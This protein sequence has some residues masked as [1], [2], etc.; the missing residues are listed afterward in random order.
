MQAEQL[1]RE[2][3]GFETFQPG[4]REVIDR[5]LDGR[6]AAAVFPTGGGKSLCYQ[7]PALALP[8][9]TVVVSPLIALMIDQVDRLQRRGIAAERLDSTRSAAE[10]ANIASDVRQ[11]RLKLL[12][13]APERLQ[14]ERLRG[15]LEH[16]QVSLLAIDEA[17]CISEWGHA[18]RPD[19][20]KLAPYAKAIGAERV[21]ALTATATA[22]VLSDICREFSIAPDCA[23]RTPF[24]RPN[25]HLHVTPTS[26]AQREAQLI[27]RLRQRPA[28]PT[29]VYVTLQRTAEQAAASLKKAGFDARPYHA[30]LPDDVRADTQAWFMQSA[31]G[32][33]AATIAFGMGIDKSDI[34]YVYHYNLAKSLESYSQEIGRAG[35]DGLP[36]TCEMFV[37]PDDL[38][39]LENFAYGDTPSPANVRTALREILSLG[40]EFSVSM[41]DLSMRHDIRPLVLSTLLT[42]LELDGV[43]QAG[44]P[45]YAEY[46]FQPLISSREI[47]SHFDGER[48]DFLAAVLREAVKAKTWFTLDLDLAATKIAST[49]DR[50]AKAIDYL[51]EQRWLELKVAGLRARYRRLKS[52]SD[53]ESLASSLQERLA[54]REHRE[55]ARLAGVLEWAAANE[56]IANRLGRYFGDANQAPCG[57]CTP[58]LAGRPVQLLPR[59]APTIS[60]AAWS[61]ALAV[62]ARNIDPLADARLFA[63][64]LCG[65][66]SPWLTR[67]KLA[68]DR[69]YGMLAEV[70]FPTV[71]ASV[72]Q[73]RPIEGPPT[74]AKLKSATSAGEP[75][76]HRPSHGDGKAEDCEATP[77][78]SSPRAARRPA[79]GL[80][81]PKTPP[82]R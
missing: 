58:C 62:R 1:L 50:V 11:G 33:V 63:K 72:Q 61:M 82:Y 38:N 73:G 66:S 79:G 42:Y 46:K 13:V 2:R 59:I 69:Q 3:F 53:V 26:A 57:N 7:L 20:L 43:L 23:I 52:P 47:L 44:T 80:D 64:F 55:I 74:A 67:A 54:E 81:A 10:A 6:S 78:S 70:P 12:Y 22:Q 16:A 5:L 75:D 36:S 27:E 56:C 40:A 65:L 39:A 25:L 45:Y 35:R 24:V 21:L 18:F 49:R 30:G 14:N 28:G 41:H 9:L 68:S 76:P 51:A 71:L 34:R 77:K 37:C 15:L 4:Q 60:A 17:H 8:G 19:Y 29:I 48:R 32:V 31:Q